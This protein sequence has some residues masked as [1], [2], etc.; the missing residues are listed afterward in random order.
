MQAVG[1][2][3][4]NKTVRQPDQ[5]VEFIIRITALIDRLCFRFFR[6]LLITIN[7]Q[8]SRKKRSDLTRSKKINL[9][10]Y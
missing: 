2:N 8:I 4:I 9:N 7:S 3:R 1:V 5:K 6:W 10:S